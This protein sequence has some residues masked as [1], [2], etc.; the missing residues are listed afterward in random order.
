LQKVGL[1]LYESN[2]VGVKYGFILVLKELLLL[3]SISKKIQTKKKRKSK[4]Q[5]KRKEKEKS[6]PRLN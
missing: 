6:K 3:N 4:Q 2:R 5:T 1:E